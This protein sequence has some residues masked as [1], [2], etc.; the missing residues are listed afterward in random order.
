MNTRLPAGERREQIL[1]VAVQVFARHGY[2]GTS[3]NDI[4]EA[5]G[6]TKPVLYQHFDSKQDLY[7]ALIDEVGHRMITA[8]AKA[9]AGA[10]NG[11]AQTESGFCAYFRWVAQDHDAF[12][13]LF[14][15]Q[16]NR[17]A[18]ATKAIRKITSEAASAIAPLIAAEIDH[19][20][21]RTIAHGLVGLAEG[22]SRRL[23]ERG[24]EFDPD[25]LGRLVSNLA[26]AGLRALGPNSR[27]HGAV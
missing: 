12:L 17:D 21:Q 5:A 24:E 23:V 4:A 10:T 14:A 15:T 26:W 27:D 8:I 16:A 20:Q 3:M 19:E 13:L 7:L 6:V 25:E 22:V 18:A 11:K 9:T 1:E 2:H